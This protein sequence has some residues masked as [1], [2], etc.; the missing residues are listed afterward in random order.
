M[1]LTRRV[2]TTLAMAVLASCGGGGSGSGAPKVTYSDN[3]AAG[4]VANYTDANW[5]FQNYL[6]D[7]GVPEPLKPQFLPALKMLANGFDL[8]LK[9]G[10]DV[11]GNI[12]QVHSM[13]LQ[14]LAFGDATKFFTQVQNTGAT[15]AG[16]QTTKVE[17]EIPANPDFVEP[18]LSDDD[19]TAIA[20]AKA[21]DAVEK[22][23][24][25][26][27]AREYQLPYNIEETPEQWFIYSPTMKGGGKGGGSSS[28]GG[29]GSAP[30]G[31]GDVRSWGWRRGDMVW[32]NGT[33]SIP[34]VPGHNAIIWAEGREVYLIDANT[35]VGTSYA[36]DVQA[37]ADR[38][39]EVRALTP[40]LNWSEGEYN[41]YY[42]YSSIY[43][44]RADSWQRINAW[45]FTEARR[46]SPYNWNFANPRATDKFYCSSLLWNAYNSVGF[47]VIWPWAL[48]A[49]G[50]VTPNQIRDSSAV[51][52]FKV[53][54]KS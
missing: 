15:A 10:Q 31:H 36:S 48:G 40:R 30:K 29:G 19:K 54:T 37:W 13:F 46:G 50:I 11:K 43:G 49:Y 38:Y 52:T 7:Y 44:C 21:R 33:G 5:L 14:Y 26:R 25:A 51:V 53:S 20:A 27:I 12:E 17:S 24:I 41:C 16:Q 4:T 28:G 6:G 22:A 47:N 9:T 39:T 1:R 32:V 34:G 18:V 23:E 45:W 3:V 8:Q 2:G 42:T 35:D